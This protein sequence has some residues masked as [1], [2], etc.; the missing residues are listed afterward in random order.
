MV[1]K[2]SAVQ[3]WTEGGARPDGA[4]WRGA[5][6]SNHSICSAN[7][8]YR[9]ATARFVEV[10]AQGTRRYRERL[11]DRMQPCPHCT[12]PVPANAK[13][14]TAC[15]GSI[16][17]AA[18]ALAQQPARRSRLIPILKW[19]ALVTLV[20]GI[21][22]GGFTY[23][24]MQK[25]TQVAT[26]YLEALRK[27]DLKTVC[28]MYMYENNCVGQ[29]AQFQKAFSKTGEAGPF[30]HASTSVRG[31]SATSLNMTASFLTGKSNP[32]AV[33]FY[34]SPGKARPIGPMTLF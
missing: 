27:G 4:P 33:V 34:V 26:A 20:L 23:W 29:L 30:T 15:G 13:F 24:Q 6:M 1:C 32:A 19:T 3:M 10:L 31:F 18:A 2:A 14:C 16:T 8:P 7:C 17:P 5:A 21:L 22:G 9:G 25:A 11:I 12:T 28:A